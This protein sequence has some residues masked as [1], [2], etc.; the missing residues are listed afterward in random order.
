MRWK[1]VRID[2]TLIEEAEQTAPK[3]GYASKEEV[4]RDAVR[5]KLENTLRLIEERAKLEAI[6][7]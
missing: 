3:L 6:P 7:A 5:R 1:L 2:K 4:I